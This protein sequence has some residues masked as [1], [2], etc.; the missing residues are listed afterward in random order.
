M[1]I[2][3]LTDMYYFIPCYISTEELHCF[4]HFLVRHLRSHSFFRVSNLK[5]CQGQELLQ[6]GAVSCGTFAP[7]AHR[8]CGRVA[9]SRQSL[10]TC[11]DLWLFWFSDYPH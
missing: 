1:R 3:V 9:L 7:A 10:G 4:P 5:A 8:C 11:V 6:A 2:Y